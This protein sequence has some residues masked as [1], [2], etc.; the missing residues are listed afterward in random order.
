[1]HSISVV[2]PSYNSHATVSR[3]LKSLLDSPKS[4]LKEVIVVDSS[5]DAQ[6][7]ALLDAFRSEKLRVIHLPVKTPPAT[8]RNLGARQASGDILAFLDSDA[9]AAQD[10][11]EKI[12]AAV[13]Q[14]CRV[15]GGSLSL[16]DF[17]KS[18]A[19]ALAQ[20]FLQFNEFLDVGKRRVKMFVPS[21]NLFC[22]RSL[23]DEVGGFPEIR[24]SEDVLF[25]LAVA[26]RAKVFFDPAIKIFHIFREDPGAYFGYRRCPRDRRVFVRASAFFARTFVLERR[27]FPGLLGA[28]EGTCLKSSYWACPS[29]P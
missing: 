10:W 19:L 14:G 3:T 6:T 22:E 28:G 20:Y 23:F 13:E 27:I 21:C 24:A 16:P 9:Y 2:I 12:T 7:P 26:K 15:G 25:G 8:A 4:L 5:D 1:M 29:I 18:K 11:L 17:Q